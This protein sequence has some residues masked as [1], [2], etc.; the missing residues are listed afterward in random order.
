MVWSIIV[1]NARRGCRMVGCGAAEVKGCEGLRRVSNIF[2]RQTRYT[3]CVQNGDRGRGA[4][5]ELNE[6][7]RLQA[8]RSY[9]ILDTDP[10]KAFDD[11]TILASHI[12]QTPVAM[13]SLIDSERQWFKSK[14]GVKMNETPREVSFCAVAIQQPDLF[15]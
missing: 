3:C 6:K 14:V 8:L 4:V 7:A 2:F 10:E 15:V 11:L 12:C 9:K 13:I 1:Q 5:M